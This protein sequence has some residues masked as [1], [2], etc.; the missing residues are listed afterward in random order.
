MKPTCF[1]LGT[2]VH[3]N[4]STV[5]YQGTPQR[6]LHISKPQQQNALLYIIFTRNQ[7][8]HA[9]VQLA[10]LDHNAH[11]GREVATNKKGEQIYHHKYRKQTKKWDVTP[12]KHMKKYK[13]ATELMDAVM[14]EQKSSC[15]PLKRPRRV[16]RGINHLEQGIF[17]EQPIPHMKE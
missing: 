3:Q 12:T 1:N 8:Y 11:V 15:A 5:C 13:Y 9:R 7:V 16:D 14:T 4:L 10:V 17:L 2:Q 6:E